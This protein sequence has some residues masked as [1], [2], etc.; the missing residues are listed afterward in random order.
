MK[1]P[2]RWAVLLF[3]LATLAACGRSSGSVR[4]SPADVAQASA[5]TPAATPK[6]DCGPGSR[7]ETGLQ[8]RASQADID[9]SIATGGITCNTELVGSFVTT[10]PLATVGGWKVERYVDPQ[11][12]ECAYYDATTIFPLGVFSDAIGVNVMDM[13]DPSRPVLSTRLTSPAMLSPHES[14]NISEKRGILAAVLGNPAF[15]PGVVDLYDISQDC[16]NPILK[17]ISLLGVF[18]HESGMSPDGKTFFSASPISSTLAAIDISDLSFPLPLWTSIQ[19]SHGLSISADGNRAYVADTTGFVKILDISQ[20]Q[21]R[22]RNPK[23]TEISKLT[24]DTHSIPQNAV[25]VTIKGK[26][27]LV[28]VD[29]FGAGSKVGA[30]RIID[31]SDETRPKVISNLRLEVHQPENFAA[32]AGDPGANGTAYGGYA[33]HYCN[34]PTLVDPPIVACSMILSGLRIFDIRDPYHPREVAYFSAP[35]MKGAA[36]YSHPAFA[37]ERKEVWFSDASSGFYAVRVTNGA[38]P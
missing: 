33:A 16:R 4:L 32:I 35:G 24:W 2:M 12:H 1:H 30:A 8:G 26:P 15:G 20:I 37:P 23:V 29:E 9:R 7:P 5:I 14:L 19:N 22:V 18:G 3:V 34:V 31:I 10:D 27:Y 21:A 28:E 36:A 25:P 13:S 38:W 17:S 6:A 11:G